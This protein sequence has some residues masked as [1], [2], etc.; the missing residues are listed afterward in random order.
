M[1]YHHARFVI[2]TH[3]HPFPHWDFLLEQAQGLRTWRLH[4]APDSGAGSSSDIVAE[5]LPDH[6]T[7]YLDYEGPVSGNRGHVQRWD[8]GEYTLVEESQERV[9]LRLD[10][11]RL[12][13]EFLLTANGPGRPWRFHGLGG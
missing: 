8:S 13:G 1:L 10:G 11:Q 6:R 4:E 7:E 9:H 12:H 3:D 2:L 5:P